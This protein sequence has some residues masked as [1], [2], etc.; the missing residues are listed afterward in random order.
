MRHKIRTVIVP[1]DDVAL[2][3]HGHDQVVNDVIEEEE[4]DGWR[5]DGVELGESEDPWDEEKREAIYGLVF[6]RDDG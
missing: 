6:E 2:A 5:L 1:L 3:G 4:S